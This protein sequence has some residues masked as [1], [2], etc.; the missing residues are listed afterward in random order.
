[1]AILKYDIAVTGADN[2]NRALAGIER[3]FVQHNR[4]MSRQMGG[5]SAT[6]AARQGRAPSMAAQADREARTAA[7][8]WQRAH[9]RSADYRIRAD[10]KAHAARLRQIAQEEAAQKRAAQSLD[11]QRSQALM[12][13]YNAEQREAKRNAK[14]A[15]RNARDAHL[16]RTRFAHSAFGS[17]GNTVGGTLRSVG[18]LG[19]TALSLGGGFAMAGAVSAQMADSKRAAMLANQA[20]DPTIKASLLREAQSTKGFTTS[21]SLGSVEGFVTKTGDLSAARSAMPMLAELSLAYGANFAEMG[22]AAGQAFNV[23][24][25]EI[26][27]PLAQMEAL[28]DVMSTMAAQGTL[29]AVEIR[30][31]TKELAGLGAA[32]RKFEGGPVKLL[33]TMGAMAQAAVARG[34][35]SSA[36]EATTA[37]SR[38]AADIV[39]KPAQ[40][41]L[42][43]LGIDVF[44]DKGKTQL[45]D[46]REIMAQ[47][48]DKTGGD[49]T[50]IEEIM[51]VESAK[52]LGGFSP[53]FLQAERE[54]AALPKKDQKQKGE[55]GRAALMGEFD[56]FMNASAN[57]ADLDE[58]VASV[59]EEPAM[60]FQEAIK[61]VNTSLGGALL[62]VVMRLIP[63]FQELIPAVDVAARMF[64]KMA[65]TF[66]QN[67]LAGI[68]VIIAAKI[69]A[70]L[71][72]AGIGAAARAGLEAAMKGL[73]NLGNT[74]PAAAGALKAAG[75]GA[76]LGLSAATV[77]LTAGIVNFQQKEAI[78]DAMGDLAAAQR[79][80]KTPEEAREFRLK[81]EK[82]QGKLEPGIFENV[83]GGATELGVGAADSVLSAVGLDDAIEGTPAE[84]GKRARES[85]T[86]T[87]GAK[88]SAD[89]IINSMRSLEAKLEQNTQAIA[90]NSTGQLNRGNTPSPV[91]N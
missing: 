29:G 82:M 6:T 36:A 41:A 50:K 38:F 80:A 58:R 15:E 64:A 57:K 65:E 52:A 10:Q 45:K 47:I 61:D 8:Y 59:M 16:E 90:S 18:A 20:G 33:K 76:A 84:A 77:I 54:N 69:A 21:E 89:G 44:T 4:T 40:D 78:V 31:L 74:S 26:K 70:D 49:M 19:A 35:A 53:L 28:R 67:P 86:W 14:Q 12:A 63:Q 62:P 23:I 43:G 25:D 24:R 42:G 1:M 32:T 46:P 22:E 37:V 73:Q 11:R 87:E 2:V 56:R 66:I 13:K 55:A 72:G 5:G 81:A 85:V 17:V 48:L 60:K 51:N 88:K 3:R 83:V 75:V 9:Q 39:K 7:M 79:S 30:D 91:K 68:G 71:A 27:D 34:G